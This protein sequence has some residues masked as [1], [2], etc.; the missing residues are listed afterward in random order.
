MIIHTCTCSSKID[1]NTV[2][3]VAILVVLTILRQSRRDPGT[4]NSTIPNP[5]IENSSPGLQSL[6]AVLFWLASQLATAQLQYTL[7]NVITRLN[8][9]RVTHAHLCQSV[10]R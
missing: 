9:I 4:G 6:V 1:P 7:E 2:T 10:P 8:A 3:H 5:G